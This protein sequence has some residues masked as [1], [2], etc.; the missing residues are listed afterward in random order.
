MKLNI[1]CVRDILL[2]LETFPIGVYPVGSLKNSIANHGRENVEYTLVKLSEANYVNV[3]YCRMTNGSFLFDSI[4]DITFQG[5]EFLE[6]IRS[7]TVWNQKLKP[8]FSSVGSASF[9]VI[10]AVAS[11][12]LTSLIS[13]KL[14]L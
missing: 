14:N 6:K 5:H 1:D 13:G 2:E 11:S 3:Q 9:E 7:D 10:S 8:I 12:L 4:L